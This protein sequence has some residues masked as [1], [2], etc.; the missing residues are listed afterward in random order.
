MV[1]AVPPKYTASTK[2]E[3]HYSA[4]PGLT[5]QNKVFGNGSGVTPRIAGRCP[6]GTEGTGACQAEL[7]LRKVS[8]NKAHN[9]S[10]GVSHLRAS[11]FRGG[12]FSA[13]MGLFRLC[14]EVLDA[15]RTERSN[16]LVRIGYEHTPEQSME[17]HIQPRLVN[18][19]PA[20]EIPRTVWCRGIFAAEKPVYLSVKYVGYEVGGEGRTRE[21]L[22][23][24]LDLFVGSCDIEQQQEYA[25]S[26]NEHRVGAVIIE[27]PRCEMVAVRFIVSAIV[28]L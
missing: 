9:T 3:A 7:F 19:R 8:P 10:I 25:D 26:D 28:C 18:V 4:P 13:L 20:V 6:E 1:T 16:D 14:A 17:E 2:K 11:L 23:D 27:V 24:E 21:L 5:E 15:F 12:F 22:E